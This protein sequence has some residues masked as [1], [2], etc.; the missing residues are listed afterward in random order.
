MAVGATATNGA[1]QS[2]G[3]LVGQ[4]AH[5]DDDRGRGAGA[6][7]QAQQSGPRAAAQPDAVQPDERQQRAGRM[8]RHVGDPRIRLEIKDSAGEACAPPR[9][10][11]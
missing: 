10:C 5:R 7:Q 1:D 2:R 3:V 9:E 11:R 6:D 8:A 4:R